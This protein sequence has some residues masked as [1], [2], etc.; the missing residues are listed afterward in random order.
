MQVEAVGGARANSP[1]LPRPHQPCKRLRW[2]AAEGATEAT[3]M[4][5]TVS[6]E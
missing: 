3:P 2:E 1:H 6:A 4:T 5:A